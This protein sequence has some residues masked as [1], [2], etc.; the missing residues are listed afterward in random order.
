MAHHKQAIKRIRTNEKRRIRNRFYRQTM[1]SN[2]RRY[3]L[4]LETGELAQARE[5][6][7]KLITVISK[8]A[9]KGVIRKEN[10]SRHISR[11]TLALNKLE[12]NAQTA[13]EE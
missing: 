10:A 12:A 1:R 6:L 5:A 8:T 13:A 4:L 2:V 3:H 11:L 9:S 7:P